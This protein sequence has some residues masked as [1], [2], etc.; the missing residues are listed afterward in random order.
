[1]GRFHICRSKEEMIA[2]LQEAPIEEI[3]GQ[4]KRSLG[5]CR[6][7]QDAFSAAMDDLF[8]TLTKKDVEEVKKI[9]DKYTSWDAVHSFGLSEDLEEYIRATMSY[10]V[11]LGDKPFFTFL[12]AAVAE[13]LVTLTNLSK[14]GAGAKG[15]RLILRAAF[16]MISRR[17]N[18]NP[19]IRLSWPGE[20]GR[21]K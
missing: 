20:K 9:I 11:K 1:M 5:T 10:A 2:Y 4:F 12:V 16:D 21:S 3:A 17:L 13:L 7:C 19:K 8:G 14:V 15:S 18:D 6:T